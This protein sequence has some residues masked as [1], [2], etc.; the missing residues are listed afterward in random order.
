MTT[1]YKEYRSRIIFVFVIMLLVAGITNVQAQS[2]SLR[3]IKLTQASFA[4]LQAPKSAAFYLPY[5]S[6]PYST[7][8]SSHNPNRDYY[9]KIYSPSKETLKSA[10]FD[11]IGSGVL[12]YFGEQNNHNYTPPNNQ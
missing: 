2:D 3:A 6:Y 10:L 8:Q 7:T 5:N 11:L 9:R 4:S 12:T 1:S